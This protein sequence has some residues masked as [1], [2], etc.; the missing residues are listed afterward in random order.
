MKCTFVSVI[1]LSVALGS[2]G[3]LAEGPP[4]PNNGEGEFNGAEN[5]ADVYG[6]PG[7]ANDAIDALLEQTNAGLDSFAGRD[8][9]IQQDGVSNSAEVTQQGQTSKVGIYQSTGVDSSGNLDGS[10]HNT[11]TVTTNG[12]LNV[13]GIVQ[14]SKYDVADVNVDGESNIALQAQVGPNG[15]AGNNTAE[16]NISGNDN[17]VIQAQG[18]S[19]GNAVNN[20]AHV[21]LNENNGGWSSADQSTIEQ[22]QDGRNNEAYVGY[23]GNEN[24]TGTWN[25]AEVFQEQQGDGN[26]AVLYG[27]VR[28]TTVEMIQLGDDNTAEIHNANT[29][30]GAILTVEQDGSNNTA[31]LGDYD[32]NGQGQIGDNSNAVSVTVDQDGQNHYFE[33]KTIKNGASVDVAQMAGGAG[34][35]DGNK[36]DLEIVKDSAELTV[37]QDG[38]GHL[39]D[40]DIIVGATVIFDQS[41]TNHEAYLASVTNAA[42]VTVSQY[43]QGHLF[44]GNNGG[45]IVDGATVTVD[46]SGTGQEAY[47]DSTGT[48]NTVNIAQ[49]GNGNQ[50]WITQ[51]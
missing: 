2:S 25:G 47:L 49:A 33:A 7:L 14:M 5:A 10:D 32:N 23:T 43:G 35:D 16:I 11:A 41:G 8:T 22:F 50:A 13:V 9:A 51:N 21:D 38:Q 39:F 4:Y 31:M 46:Q 19:S 48:S 28:D 12:T 34:E 36:V 17:T 37:S 6:I 15:G 30:S 44:T 20:R 26:R 45:A 40:G 27:I 29:S 3:V 42:D 1:A 18:S 24:R